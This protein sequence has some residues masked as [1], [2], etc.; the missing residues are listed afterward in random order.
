M[1]I[2]CLSDIL[3][4]FGAFDPAVMPDADICVVAGNITQYGLSRHSSDEIG[5]ART[6]LAALGQHYPTFIIPGVH[7]IGVRNSDFSR[8]SGVTPVLNTLAGYGDLKIYGVA[9]TP[10]HHFPRMATMFDHM[11]ADPREENE[12][13]MFEPVDI[14]ISHAPPYGCLDRVRGKDGTPAGGPHIGSSALLRYIEKHQ[15]K[16]VVCGHVIGDTGVKKIGHTLVVNAAKSILTADITDI[17]TIQPL[18]QAA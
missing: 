8:I 5:F 14:V 15:P 10:A 1:R 3:S 16:I 7:D 13:F 6:W 18:S 12:A 11:T 2:L 17:V 9:M 4:D